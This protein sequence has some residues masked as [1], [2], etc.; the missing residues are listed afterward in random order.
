MFS[1]LTG[2]PGLIVTDGTRKMTGA[3][4]EAFPRPGDPPPTLRSCEWHLKR[5]IAE[6]LPDY[7]L[8]PKLPAWRR[9]DPAAST[10][11]HHPIRT[12]FNA[13]FESPADFRSF[14]TM[15]REEA[16]LTGGLKGAVLRLDLHAENIVA[17]LGTRGGPRSGGPVENL[18]EDL[19]RRIEWRA[20]NFGNKTRTT[21]LLRLMLL[22]IGGQADEREW[23]ELIRDH[24]HTRAGRPEHQRLHDDPAGSKSIR[25]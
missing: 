22:E 9:D 2:T 5:N 10:E 11:P 1:Q 15:V 4:N 20:A 18:L 23:A 7:I 21:S 8:P 19:K 14:E 25:D 24:L 13:A 16:A 12:A 17:Q 6:K 3:I